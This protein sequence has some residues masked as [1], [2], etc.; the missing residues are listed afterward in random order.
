MSGLGGSRERLPVMGKQFLDSVDGVLRDS[1]EHITEP[2]ERFYGIALAHRDEA[3][4]HGRRLAA[5]VAAEERPVATAHGDIPIRSL[6]GTRVDLQ[7]A[8]FEKT[9]ERLPLIQRVSH[10]PCA[11]ALG[12]NLLLD[13]VEIL[14]QFFYQWSRQLLAQGEPLLSQQTLGAVLHRVQARD[15]M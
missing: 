11:R 3:Q 2:G 8:V 1:R 10:G 6:G 13:L 14:T 15:Q 12:Q 4:Q 5:S 9:R 7:I